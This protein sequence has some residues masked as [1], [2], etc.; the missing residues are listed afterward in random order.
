MEV[1]G[2]LHAPAALSQGKS[3]WYPLDR[4]MSVIY[5]HHHHHPGALGANVFPD[6]HRS[7]TVYGDAESTLALCSS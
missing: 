6:G 5:H 2:Q 7:I 4:R 3:P 1:S